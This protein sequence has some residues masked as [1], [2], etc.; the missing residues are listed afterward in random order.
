[1]SKSIK[2]KK[3]DISMTDNNISQEIDKN[4]SNKNENIINEENITDNN[5]NEK[6]SNVKK[7]KKSKKSKKAK[8]ILDASK[9]QSIINNT[10]TTNSDI[11]SELPKSGTQ[12]E[13]RISEPSKKE[14]QKEP[15]MAQV[16]DEL[17]INHVRESKVVD[18]IYKI[19]Y[20]FNNIDY[21]LKVKPM[22]KMIDIINKIC[23]KTKMPS[24]PTAMCS[25]KSCPTWITSTAI[26]P[27]PHSTT[28]CSRPATWPS[29]HRSRITTK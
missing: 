10:N 6:K 4:N 20:V 23:K 21:Y 8:I 24:S 2:Y 25:T 27:T 14:T 1:M 26:T 22:V 18:T 5:S 11:I 3:K 15:I 19:V 13:I 28:G 16:I 12:N 29:R 17:P 7:E 9:D